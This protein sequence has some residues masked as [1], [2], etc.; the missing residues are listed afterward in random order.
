MVP[1]YLTL[2][3]RCRGTC[4]SF[5]TSLALVG[6]A[7][8]A[9]LVDQKVEPLLDPSQNKRD[10]RVWRLTDPMDPSRPATRPVTTRPAGRRPAGVASSRPA[11]SPNPASQPAGETDV[12]ATPY[13]VNAETI[14]KL[15]FHKYPLVTS[16]RENMIAAEHGLEE[17]KANLSRFEPF[18]NSDGNVTRFPQRRHAEGVAGEVTGGLQK[19]T[20]DGAVFRVE[21]GG[22]GQRV[23][24][25]EV[26]EGE[27]PVESGGG[28]LVRARVEVPF[29]GSRVRQDRV[30]NAAYQESTARGAMLSYLSNYR[31]YAL[32]GMNYYTGT[33]LYLG[34]VRAYENEIK[35]LEELLKEPELTPDDQ[36]RIQTTIGNATVLRDTYK[37][38]YQSYLLWTLEYLGIRPGEDYVLEE[39]P[40]SAGSV[41]YDQ[42]RSAEQRE[43]LLSEAYEN[44]PRFRVLNDAIKD[45]ELKRSQAIIGKNDITAFGEGTQHA[46]G[47]ESFDDRVGGWEFN[48]GISFRRNDPRVLNASIKKAEAEIRGYRAQIQAEELSVQQQVAVQSSNLTTHVESRPQILKNIEDGERQFQARRKSYFS[49]Q[50]SVLNID[51]VLSSL[52]ARATGEIRLASNRYYIALADNA[53]MSATGQVYQMAGMDV[54]QDGKGLHAAEGK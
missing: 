53:L 16:A 23:K 24:Y 48:A 33:L 15:I 49:R 17:F 45:S 6:V 32:T 26:G 34:Y 29:I 41:Y 28:G 30:I 11:A 5:L 13:R 46:F 7:G 40:V 9:G 36:R 51:D 22:S 1:R 43:K 42:T 3:D 14:P 19:D 8:C 52:E 21:G 47:A 10:A 20:F 2:G 37:T 18:V 38:S 39:P 31:S 27:D 4:R 12:L 54:S 35:T 50:S 25:G 44:N